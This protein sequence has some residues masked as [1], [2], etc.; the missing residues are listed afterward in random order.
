MGGISFSYKQNDKIPLV[1]IFNYQSDTGLY[2]SDWTKLFEYILK[3]LQ[4]KSTLVKG[5]IYLD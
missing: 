4:K 1:S 5:H 2:F 3:P